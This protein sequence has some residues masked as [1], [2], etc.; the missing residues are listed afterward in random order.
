[1]APSISPYIIASGKLLVK[2]AVGADPCVCPEMHPP[3]HVT[4]R[5]IEAK[6]IVGADPCVC[7]EMHPPNTPNHAGN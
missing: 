3:M 2:I 7:P 1:M 6:K 4:R 5:V